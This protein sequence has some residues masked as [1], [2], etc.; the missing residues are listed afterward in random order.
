M[1][2]ATAP[3]LQLEL[4]CARVLLPAADDD[5]GGFHA[6]LD[7]LERRL[8]IDEGA[9]APAPRATQPD[10]AARAPQPSPTARSAVAA[11][12]AE[13]PVAPAPASADVAPPAP[14]PSEPAAA[15]E[16][17]AA[18]EGSAGGEPTAGD[19]GT[20]DATTVRRHWPDV[21][22]RVAKLRRATWTL[23]SHNAQVADVSEGRVV[24]AITTAG[25]RDT[26]LRG[27]HEEIV[28]QA[29]IDVLGLGA[30]VEAVV[31][32]SA[33]PAATTDSPASG[34]AGDAAPPAGPAA[35]P[36]AAGDDDGPSVDDP[37][38]DD[39]GLSHQ[40]LLERQLGAKVIGE[41]DHT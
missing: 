4:I 21:L 13:T 36:V 20:L 38:A 33:R 27:G 8:A 32:P 41:Y 14:T 24:L 15:T 9:D 2:G 17:P 3:R 37:D 40:Q 23:V 18:A 25:L 5:N 22:E 19:P 35:S 28:R 16:A 6:R 29:L 10:R 31:D 12:P 39:T 26:F 30:K 11:E 34:A 7:R 1:R